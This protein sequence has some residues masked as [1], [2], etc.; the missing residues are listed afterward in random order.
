MKRIFQILL[1]LTFLGCK[2]TDNR[3]LE[4]QDT[5]KILNV[6]LNGEEFLKENLNVDTL[7]FLRNKLYNKGYPTMANRFKIESLEDNSR[8]R[9]ANLGPFDPYDGRERLSVFKFEYKNDTVK[10]G[11]Y[12]HGSNLF[13]ETELGIKKGNWVILNQSASSGGKREKFEFENE[14]WYKELKKKVK[15]RQSMFPPPE[16]KDN[17]LNNGKSEK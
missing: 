16:P 5:T 14:E 7:F 2:P 9:M 3:V 6:I 10:V 15:P 17:N 8:S 1:L 13:Y 12:E 11:M 4:T